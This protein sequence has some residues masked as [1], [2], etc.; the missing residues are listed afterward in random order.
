M[1]LSV[2]RRRLIELDALLLALLALHGLDHELRHPVATPAVVSAV[3]TLEFALVLFALW[4]ALRRHP[5]AQRA[6]S[7]AGFVIAAAYA[8]IHLP[9]DWGALSQP[10]ADIGVDALSWADLALTILVGLAVGVAAR[11]QPQPQQQLN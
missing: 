6:T 4:L 11:A 10:Y 8:I 1:H 7:V 3:G 5:S 9:P 2:T